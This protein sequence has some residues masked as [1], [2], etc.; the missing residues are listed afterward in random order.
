VSKC[1][2]VSWV[3]DSI[4]LSSTACLR[5]LITI[6]KLKQADLPSDVK[7][8]FTGM[9]KINTMLTTIKAIQDY[10]PDLIISFGTVGKINPELSG[11][12]S[13]KKVIQRDMVA[14][15]LAPR[16]IT[17]FCPRPYEHFSVN[18]DY[19]CGT[20]DSFV[21]EHDPWLHTQKVD[22]VLISR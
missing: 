2:K 11:L 18:G 7:I 21:T 13:I 16:G 4:L 1:L 5:V 20:G 9:G 10:K 8:V 3:I 19:V 6:L 22:G 15:P 12:L 14:D 17:P